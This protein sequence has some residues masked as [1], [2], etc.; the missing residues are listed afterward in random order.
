[1]R[2][3]FEAKSRGQFDRKIHL[4]SE[5]A[6]ILSAMIWFVVVVNI[7]FQFIY[8]VVLGATTEGSEEGFPGEAGIPG[9]TDNGMGRAMRGLDYDL[10]MKNTR[11][12]QKQVMRDWFGGE[13]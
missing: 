9:T 12:G 4:K 5:T 11:E 8:V 1:M 10:S 7:V 6:E 3:Q 2:G 13:K